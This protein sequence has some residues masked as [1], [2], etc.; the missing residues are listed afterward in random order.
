MAWTRLQ[1]VWTWGKLK[2]RLWKF[3]QL[4]DADAQ[5]VNW[6]GQLWEHVAGWMGW[7]AGTLDW[8]CDRMW[9]DK[10]V[11][12]VCISRK[13][14]A[15]LWHGIKSRSVLWLIISG[16][17]KRNQRIPGKELILFSQTHCF[18]QTCDGYFCPTEMVQSVDLSKTDEEE[19]AKMGRRRR[20]RSRRMIRGAARISASS[21][22]TPSSDAI[23]ERIS[24][25][26]DRIICFTWRLKD[27]R[28]EQQSVGNTRGWT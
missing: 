5:R 3:R 16:R 25:N 14:P 10:D 6:V 26:S 21:Y 23:N 13:S 20:G 27:V 9:R 28:P 17:L 19:E 12:A 4:Q 8:H 1:T 11:F 7:R 24:T 18:D 2:T 22:S 15:V